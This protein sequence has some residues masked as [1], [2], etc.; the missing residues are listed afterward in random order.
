MTFRSKIEEREIWEYT[1]PHTSLHVL[2]MAR[3]EPAQVN[4]LNLNWQQRLN[5][6]KINAKVVNDM[7]F[8]T[9]VDVIYN[10]TLSPTKSR[11][12][13]CNRILDPIVE[14]KI[15]VKN[16]ADIC[17]NKDFNSFIVQ[18]EW[19]DIESFI[20]QKMILHLHLGNI[21]IECVK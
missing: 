11:F 6:T 4:L 1:L 19:R 10:H 5:Q 12:F 21:L 15:A 7:W 20:Y 2:V 16:R 17:M 9:L 14:R 3:Q 8:L 13:R 18:V